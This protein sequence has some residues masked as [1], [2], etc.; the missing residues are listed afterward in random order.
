MGAVA[1][2]MLAFIILT[3]VLLAVLPY[4]WG[5]VGGTAAFIEKAGSLDGASLQPVL[6]QRTQQRR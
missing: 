3:V 5:A 4:A 6:C 1:L 2:D